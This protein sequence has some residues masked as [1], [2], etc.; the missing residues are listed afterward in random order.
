[1]FP[2]LWLPY[3]F[4][5][6][7]SLPH[8][9][10]QYMPAMPKPLSVAAQPLYTQLPF[11]ISRHGFSYSPISKL[12]STSSHRT[13]R[14][15]LFLHNILNSK[16]RNLS[17]TSICSLCHLLPSSS[18]KLNQPQI[19][20]LT[21]LTVFNIPQPISDFRASLFSAKIPVVTWNSLPYPAWLIYSLF[22]PARQNYLLVPLLA[23]PY[24][25]VVLYATS[26]NLLLL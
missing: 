3:I 13:N 14:N 2:R 18:L 22:P 8:F 24:V 20:S 1:M 9:V 19:K 6:E 4:I 15:Y 17:V 16:F 11:W 25:S 5:P 26:T 21:S 23:P 12:K 10:W 7:R